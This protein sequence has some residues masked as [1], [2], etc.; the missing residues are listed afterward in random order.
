MIANYQEALSW[1]TSRL[2]Y[3]QRQGAAAYKP[4]LERSL[5]L[6]HWL[7]HPHKRYP[8]LHVGGTNGKGSVSHLLAAALQTKGL[9]TGLYTSPHLYDFRERIKIN[10]QKIRSEFVVDFVNRF[11]AEGQAIDPSFFELTMAMAFDYFAQEAVDVA[12]IEV[13]MGG[14]LDSTNVITPIVSVITNIGWDHM[15]FLGDTLPKI[16]FEKAGIIKPEVPIVIGELQEE[17]ADVFKNVAQAKHAPLLFASEAYKDLLLECEL[18]GSYQLKNSKT[19]YAAL[20]LLPE[21]LKPTEEQIRYAF[22]HVVQLTGLRGRWEVL[23]QQPLV[24]AD[25][26]HN[27]DGIQIVFQQLEQVRKGKLYIV[28]GMVSDKDAIKIFTLLPKDAYYIFT[29]PD[30]PRAMPLD[31]LEKAAAD[32]KLNYEKVPSVP[33]AYQRALERAQPHDT[34]YVGG[35][36]FVVGDLLKHLENGD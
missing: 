27:F 2:P 14:R 34:I 36:T 1:L 13:G 30:V 10:G 31:Q 16:A 20:Q 9:K 21:T 32:F 19:A 35:S 8:T 28:W 3:F 11:M 5:A 24:I 33:V 4:G 29:T 26:A 15:Q 25:T 23:S 18:K 7:G 6:M 12:V 17:V 22:S